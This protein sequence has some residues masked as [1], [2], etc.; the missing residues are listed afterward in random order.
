[1]RN[2]LYI[3]ILSLCFG[4]NFIYNEDAWYSVLSP[5]KITSITSAQ[6]K[7][8]FSSLNGLFIYNKDNKDFFYS[9]YMLE[10][11]DNKKIYIVHYDLFR[12]NIWILNKSY[13]L[14]K[15]TFSNVWTKIN[16]YDFNITPRTIK[17]IGSNSNYVIIKTVNNQYIFLDPYTGLTQSN[18]ENDI[19]ES[20]L[21]SVNWSSSSRE[22]IN[23]NS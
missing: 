15:S 19:I 5:G 10:N 21:I 2:I 20:E 11:L 12:D 13:L 16:F 22:S 14:F 1:M 6:N 9:D 7:V 4:K 23:F 17:N 3:I 8:F 18:I